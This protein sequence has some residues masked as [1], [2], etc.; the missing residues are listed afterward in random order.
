M[1]L[2]Y[3]FPLNYNANY[4][5]QILY[6]CHSKA[7]KLSISCRITTSRHTFQYTLSNVKPVIYKPSSHKTM[8]RTTY[9][10]IHDFDVVILFI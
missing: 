9:K 5:K 3:K 4:K 10:Q 1:I 7:L 6:L 8:A 2:N